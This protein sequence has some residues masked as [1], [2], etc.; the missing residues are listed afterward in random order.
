[1]FSCCVQASSRARSTLQSIRLS[2]K[3]LRILLVTFNMGEHALI[4]EN[5]S[6][7][8]P[9]ETHCPDLIIIGLQETHEKAELV[10]T[11]YLTARGHVLVLDSSLLA[12]RQIVYC[13]KNLE[14]AIT[15]VCVSNCETKNGGVASRGKGGI[16]LSMMIHSRYFC[17]IT[18]HLASH[19]R[20]LRHRNMDAMQ[21]LK[22]VND[23]LA[24]KS[25]CGGD[26]DFTFLF[27][28]LNYR[29]GSLSDQAYDAGSTVEEELI[30]LQE[31]KDEETEEAQ[32]EFNRKAD[33]SGH[34]R[35]L[36]MDLINQKR[37]Q[38]I[39]MHC[40]L[41]HLMKATDEYQYGIFAGFRE[42]EEFDFPPTFKID[43]LT[44]TYDEKR[45]PSYCDRILFKSKDGQG[46][47]QLLLASP[48]NV[49][50]SDHQ[51]VLSLFELN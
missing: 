36:I 43:R 47:N 33:H 35:E 15:N 29:I 4:S 20:Y 10:L 51:P 7:L 26:W 2:N 12:S 16:A 21:V 50:S 11:K 23:D 25:K 24:P 42:K 49:T 9:V 45:I 37:Y 6:S 13:M 46:L 39:L 44:G 14:H 3:K 19:R 22:M 30:L 17:F 41:R 5:L 27:G 32:R 34:E 48:Q 31:P 8:L 38:N 40:Q 1:M 18:A 28:D